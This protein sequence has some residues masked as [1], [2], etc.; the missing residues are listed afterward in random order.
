MPGRR[1][2]ADPRASAIADD[3][4][5]SIGP[6]AQLARLR[7]EIERRCVAE[8]LAPPTTA[9]IRSRVAH[10]R[11]RADHEPGG[12]IR[13]VVDSV[14]LPS[15]VLAGGSRDRPTLTLAILDPIRLIVG[16]SLQG[17][18]T[19]ASKAAAQILTRIGDGR[20][21]DSAIMV[22]SPTLRSGGWRE[23][24]EILNLRDVRLGSPTGASHR[25]GGEVDDLLGRTL[26][27]IA[28]SG[29]TRRTFRLPERPM[30]M[31]EAAERINEAVRSHNRLV[32]R[33]RPAFRL[34]LNDQ[35]QLHD[36][37]SRFAAAQ[38]PCT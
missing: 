3:V 33:I 32:P 9:S 7:R 5:L 6:L 24:R 36:D 12:G 37:L 13:L 8:D 35:R 18:G 31:E 11:W 10:Q 16:H 30:S 22:R 34:V 23:L 2:C 38:P 19:S 28:L 14:R 15:A 27:G 21:S 1:T 20:V 29:V 4:I 25:L 26:A 17:P